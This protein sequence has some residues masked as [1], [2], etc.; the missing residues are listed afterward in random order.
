MAKVREKIGGKQAFP[1]IYL[2]PKDSL[3]FQTIKLSMF[4]SC[5]AID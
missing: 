2:D 5:A 1:Q 4:P 3:D